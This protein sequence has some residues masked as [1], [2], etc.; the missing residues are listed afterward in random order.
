M[1]VVLETYRWLYML[2]SYVQGDQINFLDLFFLD[3]VGE[4]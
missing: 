1:S 2:D 4:K 3:N